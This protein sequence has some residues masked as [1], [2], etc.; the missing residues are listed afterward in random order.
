MQQQSEEATRW[1]ERMHEMKVQW[2]A[3]STWESYAPIWRKLWRWCRP[4]LKARR[5]ATVHGLHHHSDIFYSYFAM[6]YDSKPKKSTI[7]AALKVAN[8]AFKLHGLASK[9]AEPSSKLMK[10][11]NGRTRSAPVKKKVPIQPQEIAIIA[12]KWGAPTAARWQRNV[13][14]AITLMFDLALRYNDLAQL[15]VDMLRFHGGV[16]KVGMAMAKNNQ[17]AEA[18]WLHVC[19]TGMPG[20]TFRRLRRELTDRGFAV[21]EHGK[22][23]MAWPLYVWPYL[24]RTEESFEV[25]ETLQPRLKGLSAV[26][27]AAGYEQFRGLFKRALQECLG[28]TDVDGMLDAFSSHSM[29]RGANHHRMESGMPKEKRMRNGRW[30]SASA[31]AGYSDEPSTRFQA[32]SVGRFQLRF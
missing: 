10:L 23:Q 30:N 9:A 17:T 20:C 21:P 1:A 14:L 13:V 29:R 4:K 6:L 26:G 7:P 12:S 19:D 16:C 28:Y 15:R 11:A 31:E 25:L 8:F 2:L 22:V 5:A 18:S 3:P 32:D 27:T 24:Q